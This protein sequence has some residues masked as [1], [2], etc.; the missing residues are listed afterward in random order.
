MMRLQLEPLDTLFFR[1]GTPFAADN[2]A[3]SDA[4]GIFPPFPSSITGALRAA[5]ARSNGWSGSGRWS[6]EH[7]QA[8]GP[9]PDDLGLLSFI[10][11]LLLHKGTPLFPAPLHLQGS[12]TE[13]GWTPRALLQPGAPVNCDLGPAARLPDLPAHIQGAE[14]RSLKPGE[15][16]W[17]KPAGLEAV[18][19][20][21]L[22]EPETLVHS[23][24]LWQSEPRIGIARDS[25]TRTAASGMLYTSRHVRLASGI[26]LGVEI[27]GLGPEWNEPCGA[28]FPLGGESRMAECSEWKNDLRLAMPLAGIA[29]TRRLLIVAL[30]PLD[31]PNDQALGHSPLSGLGHTRVISAC[32]GPPQRIGGWD[33]LA[34]R[35][36]PLQT[37]L[38][39]GSVLFCELSDP[40]ALASATTAEGRLPRLGARQRW[41]YGVVAFGTWSDPLD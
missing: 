23:L 17:L 32:L 40:A 28:L 41:G 24:Q 6:A 16:W 25:S 14:R 33:S 19:R 5:L 27:H 36:L 35:P 9:G 12:P 37:F 22:P 4:G 11:P 18:L 30:T 34:R 26:S 10:G 3:P 31:L 1:D 39:A 7:N 20:G 29:A 21:E 8:L 15:G 38:P 2:S 13:A